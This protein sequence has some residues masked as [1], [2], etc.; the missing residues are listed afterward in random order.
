M[1]DE[2]LTSCMLRHSRYENGA[3]VR[4][5]RIE[6]LRPVS[7]IENIADIGRRPNPITGVA[8]AHVDNSAKGLKAKY[9]FKHN[10][11]TYRFRTLEEA[12]KARGEL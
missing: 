9:T 5:D 1:E 2:G 10:G 4:N 8:G 12:V 6:D 7:R 11:K 3:L